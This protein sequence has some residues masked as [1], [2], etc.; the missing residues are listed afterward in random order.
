MKLLSNQMSQVA[1]LTSLVVFTIAVPWPDGGQSEP[2]SSETMERE[3]NKRSSGEKLFVKTTCVKQISL[4]AC[5][6]C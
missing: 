3:R 6:K 5:L 2:V 4:I 1:M